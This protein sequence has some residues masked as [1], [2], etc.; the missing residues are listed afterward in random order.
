MKKLIPTFLF[1]FLLAQVI[2]QP[3]KKVSTYLLTQYNK[4]LYDYTLGN[5]PSGVGLGLQTFLIT[6]RS[7]SRPWNL[8]VTSI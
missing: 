8:L 2:A 6:R 5:N 1:C 7:L 3:Q 4:T